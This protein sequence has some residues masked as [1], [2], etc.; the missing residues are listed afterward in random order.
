[1]RPEAQVFDVVALAIKLGLIVAFV[2]L[3]SRVAA[4]LIHR[5]ERAIRDDGKGPPEEREA[6][7]RTIGSVLRGGSWLL[8]I[9]IAVLMGVRELGFDISPAL[10]AAGGFGVAA[11]LGAQTLVRD[12]IGGFFIILDNQ[13]SVGDVV[14]TGGIAGKVE[15]FTLRHAEIRDGEGALHFV[16]NGEM[17]VVTNL[18]KR[19]ATPLVRVPVSA[20]EDPERAIAVLEEVL[21][22]VRRDPRIQPHLMEDPRVLG[23]EDITP[24]QFTLLIRLATHPAKRFEVS[25]AVRLRSLER[26]RAAGIRTAASGVTGPAGTSGPVPASGP[27]AAPGPAAQGPMAS[28]GGQS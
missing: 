9:V 16:P 13:F 12:W 20:E 25:R 4:V 22:E 5:V 18:S 3:G 21:A 24:G 28:E 1:M 14:R 2:F 7:A 19:G 11:G 15:A 27:A 6:R 26:L 8:L 23:I 17:R 10:A